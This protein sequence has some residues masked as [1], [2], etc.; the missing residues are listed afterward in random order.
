LKENKAKG[1][2]R[3]G[4][5]NQGEEGKGEGLKGFMKETK[6]AECEET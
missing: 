5:E 2:L 3:E 1:R 6:T 4:K